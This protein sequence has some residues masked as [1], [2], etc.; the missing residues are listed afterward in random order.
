MVGGMER[1]V[2]CYGLF[3]LV[4]K[5]DLSEMKMVRTG[6]RKKH[7]LPFGEISINPIEAQ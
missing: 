1:G 3:P 7:V 2:V 4:L 5:L 6:R